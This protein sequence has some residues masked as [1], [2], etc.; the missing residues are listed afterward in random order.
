MC[1]GISPQAHEGTMHR[2]E[3]FEPDAIVPVCL[4][5]TVSHYPTT[6]RMSREISPPGSEAQQHPPFHKWKGSIH[7]HLNPL[8]SRERK[9]M[10]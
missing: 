6:R 4:P 10:E 9:I 8:P 1:V 2:A 3:A 7:P 5:P